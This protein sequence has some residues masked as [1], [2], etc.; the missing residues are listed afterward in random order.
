[1]KIIARRKLTNKLIKKEDI[2][3]EI[4]LINGSDTDYI[5]PN[6]NIY[7]DYGNGLFYPKS[8][9]INK[10]NGYLYSTITY[11]NK[12]IQRRVHILVA[13]TYLPNPNNYPIVMH[14]DD[15]K[16]N[17]KLENLK[18][19]TVAENTKDAFDKGLA[20]NNKS[21]DDNQS[22]HICVFNLNGKLLYKFGSISETAR[23]LNVA[24]TTILNQCNYNVKTKPRCGYW[25]RYLTE[26]EN[27]GFVL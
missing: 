9:F 23:K 8:N 15:D 1:M 13:E 2:I 24:K 21:W 18:W 11:K 19:G 22:I 7:K 12:Q 27:N 3:E 10:N 17:P 25:F 20:Y 16:S 5:S 14:K 6:G 26:Y 4:R